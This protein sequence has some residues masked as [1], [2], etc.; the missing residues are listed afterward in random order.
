[1]NR[2]SSSPFPTRGLLGALATSV[3]LW[4]GVVPTASAQSIASKVEQLG[5]ITVVQVSQMMSARRDGLL[6]VQFELTNTT[7]SNQRVRYRFK[8]LDSSGF[9]VWDEEPW[10]PVIVHGRQKTLHRV[11]APTRQASDFRIELHADD[12]WGGD[13]S[14]PAPGSSSNTTLP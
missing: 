2:P 11:V 10:K 3:L 5:Q 7:D 13:G 12:N 9:T 14:A 8:W 6:Q 4:S 1:M